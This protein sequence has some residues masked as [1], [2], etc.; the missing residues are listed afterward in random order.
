MAGGFMILAHLL[1]EFGAMTFLRGAQGSL[2]DA[3]RVLVAL[4]VV[5]A[6]KMVVWRMQFHWFE[7]TA[8]V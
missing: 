8:N 4:L 2:G 7:R 6:V 1:R 3:A 5:G